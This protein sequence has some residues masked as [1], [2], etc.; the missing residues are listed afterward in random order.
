[1]A[2]QTNPDGK[3]DSYRFL[4]GMTKRMVK[5]WVSLDQPA[6]IPWTPLRKPLNTCTVAMI[7]S[8]GIALK[9]DRPFNKEIERRDPWCSDPSYR[10]IPRN[11]LTQDIKCYHLHFN[12]EICERDLGCIFPLGQLVELEM[13]GEIGSAAPSHYSYM[14][15]TLRPQRFLEESLPAMI[16]QLQQEN[17]DVVVLIPV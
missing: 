7:T 4:E 16:R 10:V 6:D 11:T 15:Y 5:T 8:G 17:V 13:R 1:M 3:V 2:L 14:G 9:T 12:P